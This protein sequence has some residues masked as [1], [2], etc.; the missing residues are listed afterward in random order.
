VD[1]F[2]GAG[3]FSDAFQREGFRVVRAVE[4]NRKAAATYDRNID[5]LLDVG[6][7]RAFRPKG[8]CDVI[9]A[10]PPCQGFSTLG[11]RDSS[12]PRNQLSL[13][14]VRWVREMKPRVVVIENVA[15]FLNAPVW[16]ILGRRL[17]ALGYEV[18]SDV[19][20]AAT[21]GV[22]QRR[23]RSLTVAIRGGGELSPL[24]K[25]PVVT[26]RDAWDGLSERPDGKNL[27]IHI[28][29]TPLALAR[30]KV[31]P[32]GGD[33]R[34]IMKR[35]PH[36]APPSWWNT[37]GEVTDVWGRMRWDEPANTLRTIFVNPSKGRYIH[38]NQHRVITLREAARLQSIPDDFEFADTVPRIVA[39]QIGNSVPTLLGR[40]VARAVSRYL[41]Q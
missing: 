3:L 33:K 5:T 38:P 6:D 4:L 8:R 7:V 20:D 29:P 27:H 30:M 14:V 25:R 26:V 37:R 36:L 18:R 1:L 24:R 9:I 10:G 39:R 2:A 17:K 28:P 34:D 41:D 13:E 11:K 12:D 16:Q 32:A 21:L 23:S 15:A 22:P 35:A 31:I 40:A 19:H